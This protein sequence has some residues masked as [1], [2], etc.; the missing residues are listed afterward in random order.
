[1]RF[2]IRA[3]APDKIGPQFNSPGNLAPTVSAAAAD[4]A[5]L[6]AW[7][8]AWDKDSQ[9]LSYQVL[10]DGQLIYATTAP[11]SFWQTPRFNYTDTAPTAGKHTY[12]TVVTDGDGNKVSSPITTVTV[13]K[14]GTPA[15][16]SANLAL[17]RPTSESSFFEPDGEPGRAVDGNT[18]GDWASGHSITRTADP[19][20]LYPWWQANVGGGALEVNPWWQVDLQAD[21]AIAS[22]TLWN[23]TDCCQSGLADYYVFASSTPLD[24]ALS[25]AELAVQPGVWSSTLQADPPAPSTTIAFPAGLKVRYLLVEDLGGN[26]LSVAEVQ[27]TGP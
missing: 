5:M 23:R 11:S 10:R 9:N 17:G 27:V 13:A 25:P 21:T 6:V 24:T 22:A 1:V 14:T 8:A 2:A 3:S 15:P 18:S 20:T 7:T 19:A 4:G 12:Q 16:A 26:Q